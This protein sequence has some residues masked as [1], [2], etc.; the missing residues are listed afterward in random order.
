MVIFTEPHRCVSDTLHKLVDPFLFVRPLHHADGPRRVEP[1][2]GEEALGEGQGAGHRPDDGDHY[3]CGG[4]GQPG[5]QGMND[6]HVPIRET[7]NRQP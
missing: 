1:G 3:L 4:G 2:A 7:G 5:L 6:G